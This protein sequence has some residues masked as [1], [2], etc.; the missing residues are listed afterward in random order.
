MPELSMNAAQ[1]AAA[2]D[3]LQRRLSGKRYAALEP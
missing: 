2:A 1:Q 3:R